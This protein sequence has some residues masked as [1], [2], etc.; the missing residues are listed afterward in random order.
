MNE[1]E[2][3]GQLMDALAELVQAGKAWYRPTEIGGMY[4][5]RPEDKPS[6]PA[7]MPEGFR[8]LTTMPE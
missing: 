4:T 7:S 8:L 1:L 3:Q 5:C 2:L 6:I